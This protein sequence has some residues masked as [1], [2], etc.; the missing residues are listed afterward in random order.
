MRGSG[1]GGRA[2]EGPESEARSPE[3]PEPCPAARRGGLGSTAATAA[4]SSSDKSASSPLHDSHRLLPRAAQRRPAQSARFVNRLQRDPGL[5]RTPD[6]DRVWTT[7]A[8]LQWTSHGKRGAALVARYRRYVSFAA[9]C[10]RRYAF[11]ARTHRGAAWRRQKDGRRGQ[12]S[13]ASEWATG[14]DA[15]ANSPGFRQNHVTTLQSAL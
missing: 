3:Q 14:R 6:G 8:Y 15:N 5:A 1:P 11:V 10:R 2:A 7:K 12:R 4:M 13:A 9:R